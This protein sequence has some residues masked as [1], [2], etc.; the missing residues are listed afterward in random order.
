MPD[1]TTIAPPALRC[2]ACG[3]V[4]DYGAPFPLPMRCPACG[5]HEVHALAPFAG[6]VVRL[7]P[8]AHYYAAGNEHDGD[9]PRG[10]E[11]ERWTRRKPTRA[12]IDTS[13]AYGDDLL[14]V[15]FAASAFRPLDGAYVSCSGG[16]LPA[17]KPTDL[18]YAGETEQRFWHWR[19]GFSGAGRGVDYVA[20]VALWE[21]S[22]ETR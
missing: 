11:G 19:D 14:M 18:T 9:E 17:V 3:I 13:R 2:Y 6:D 7:A 15:C 8:G 4:G 10:R 1:T 22:G 21:W 16:P 12:V 20:T 5:S